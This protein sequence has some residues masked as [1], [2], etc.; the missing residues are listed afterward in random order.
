MCQWSACLFEFSNDRTVIS[1]AA[2]SGVTLPH[3]R[4]AV[5]LSFNSDGSAVS[6]FSCDYHV[7]F[8]VTH[9]MTAK[10]GS[11]YNAILYVE[12]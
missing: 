9:S 8:S 11:N 1:F 12:M 2:S 10:C 6:H 3:F 5:R 7:H 4:L